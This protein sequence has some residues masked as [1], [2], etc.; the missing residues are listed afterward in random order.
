MI[1]GGFLGVFFVVKL[2]NVWFIFMLF[3]KEKEDFLNLM[4]YL[5]FVSN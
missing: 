2:L 4:D 3:L 1:S 5:Y